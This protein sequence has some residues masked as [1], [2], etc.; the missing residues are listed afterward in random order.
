MMDKKVS[1]KD[2]R[3]LLAKVKHPAINCSLVDLGIVKNVKIKRDKVTVMLALPSLGIPIKDYL[4]NLIREAIMKL[5]VEV[6]VTVTEMNQKE[7][8]AFLAMEHEKWKGLP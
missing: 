1:E 8:Q 3:Q 7:I 4:V 5:D 2:V 6:D